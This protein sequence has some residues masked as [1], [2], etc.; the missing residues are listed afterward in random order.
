ML[1]IL[2]IVQLQLTLIT[3]HQHV[4][5]LV[6]ARQLGKTMIEHLQYIVVMIIVGVYKMIIQKHLVQP[7]I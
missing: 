6:Q 5:T 4:I 2:Q 1:V 7:P 3:Q